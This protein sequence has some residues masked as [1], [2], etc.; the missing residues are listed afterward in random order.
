[1]NTFEKNHMYSYK[2]CQKGNHLY[3]IVSDSR[4]LIYDI[5]NLSK[6]NPI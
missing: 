1:M 2:V 4:N 5:I 3:D 6:S